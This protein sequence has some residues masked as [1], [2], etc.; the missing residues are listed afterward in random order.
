MRLSAFVFVSV[1]LLPVLAACGFRADEGGSVKK[2]DRDLAAPPGAPVEHE[3]FSERMGERLEMTS[4]QLAGRDIQDERVLKAMRRVPRHAF[5]PE[6]M[7]HLAY[8][9]QPV[10]IGLGQTISQPYIVAFMTQALSSGEKTRVL[11]IG[12]G[13]GYQAAVLAELVKEVYTIEII[14]E[15]GRLA[16]EVCTDLGYGNIHYRIG[17]GYQGWPEAA[18]FDTIIVTAAPGHIPQPLIDQLAVGGRMII[19]VGEDRQELILLERTPDG[20]VRRRVMAVRFVPM[21][22]EAEKH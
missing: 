16:R 6:E 10:P 15:L 20:V 12:T 19:P 13:S 4:T 18:P 17:D 5:M 22:G 9:D 3:A 1:V 8:A 11:E 14:P 2:A 21:T 7:R